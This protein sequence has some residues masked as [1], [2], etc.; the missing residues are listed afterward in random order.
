MEDLPL[1]GTLESWRNNS[2][3]RW[4]CPEGLGLLMRVYPMGRCLRGSYRPGGAFFSMAV[5]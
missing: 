1:S 4:H 3:A 2:S 5:F